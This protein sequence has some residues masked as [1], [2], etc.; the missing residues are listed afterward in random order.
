M[1]EVN[2][3][4]HSTRDYH[5]NDPDCKAGPTLIQLQTKGGHAKLCPPK[6]RLVWQSSARTPT[7]SR[8]ERQLDCPI[9]SMSHRNYAPT[10]SQGDT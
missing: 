2:F 10:D 1:D 5:R 3:A 9:Q 7:D 6:D 4:R 8:W